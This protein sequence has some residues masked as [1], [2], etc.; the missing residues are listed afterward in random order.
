MI[1]VWKT[2]NSILMLDFIVSIF[3]RIG[4]DKAVAFTMLNKVWSVIKFPITIFFIHS[5][6]S[7]DDQG[8]YFTFYS[9]LGLSVFLELG[10]SNVILQFVSHEMAYVK[11]TGKIL[12]GDT[13]AKSRLSS[14][15]KLTLKWYTILSILLFI[16]LYFGGLIFFNSIDQTTYVVVWEKPWLILS[17]FFSLNLWTNSLLGFFSGC[18]QVKEVARLRFV[19]GVITSITQWTILALNFKLFAVA[20]ASIIQFIG[21]IAWL[22]FTKKETI[23]D[24]IY[25]KSKSIN[26]SWKYEIWPLQW[27]IALSW[28]S[29]YFIFQIFNPL[30]LKYNTPI[31]AGQMGL[32]MSALSAISDFSLSWVN[33][34]IPYMG[35]FIA[36]KNWSK[37][38]T[39]FKNSLIRTVL[40]CVLGLIIFNLSILILKIA[41]PSYYERFLDIYQV[42]ILSVSILINTFVGA[43]AVYLRAHKKEPYLITSITFGISNFILCYILVQHLGS[44]GISIAYTSLNI[45]ISLI[46]GTSIFIKK[47]KLWH[48]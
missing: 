38:D 2:K 25:D 18:N 45:I 20:S 14:I 11:W 48:E 17:I 32:T 44:W 26:V 47:R 12:I 19:V 8:Y 28:I 9:I 10:I 40:T 37:L 31:S 46:W 23:L 22:F 5:Y 21:G 36:L 42:S 1:L 15:L 16:L 29:G 24:L 41:F 6:L 39:L 4:L 35:S 3:K 7:P 13:K 33:T 30:L 27:K 34:K 43:L